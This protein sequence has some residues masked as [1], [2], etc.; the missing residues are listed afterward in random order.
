[1]EWRDIAGVLFDLWT[2][3]AMREIE[4]IEEDRPKKPGRRERERPERQDSRRGGR[5]E[6]GERRQQRD[7]REDGGRKQRDRKKN[8]PKD[9]RDRGVSDGDGTFGARIFVG[10]GKAEQIRPGELV[11][12]LYNESGAPDGVI[13]KLKLFSRHALLDVNEEWAERIIKAGRRARFRGRSFRI[14]MDEE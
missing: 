11:G 4:M 7:G 3:E 5:E 9:R 13:G 10:L 14:R 1:M 12:M 6:R 8:R 2:G